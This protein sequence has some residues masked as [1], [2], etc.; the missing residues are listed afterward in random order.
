M[1]A[2]LDSKEHLSRIEKTSSNNKLDTAIS[3]TSSI[4]SNFVNAAAIVP[5][6][7]PV[8]QHYI[9]SEVRKGIWIKINVS[10]FGIEKTPFSMFSALEMILQKNMINK[11]IHQSCTSSA[12]IQSAKRYENIQENL[13]LILSL[14]SSTQYVK[15]HAY[16]SFVYNI[17][18]EQSDLNILLDFGKKSILIIG[19]FSTTNLN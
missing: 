6:L 10:T 3:S 12:I 14:Y 9:S 2:H 17:L 13:K 7:N 11:I 1:L 5:A 16:G 8:H 18:S 15:C 4:S 19:G